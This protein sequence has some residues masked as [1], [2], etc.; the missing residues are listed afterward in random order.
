VGIIGVEIMACIICKY[1][2]RFIDLDW[3]VEH[4]EECGFELGILDEDGKP[5]PGKGEDDETPIG[6]TTV[7]YRSRLR[8][9]VQTAAAPRS[10]QPEY[11]RSSGRLPRLGLDDET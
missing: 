7:G 11:R 6:D 8:E 5:I 1:C 10:D 2:D 4:E 3:N 9:S